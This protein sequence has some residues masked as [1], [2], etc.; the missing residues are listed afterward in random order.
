[1]SV[2]GHGDGDCSARCIEFNVHPELRV[3]VGAYGDL[4]VIQVL[5][6]F[7]VIYVRLGA[8]AYTEIVDDKGEQD[9]VDVMTKEVKG[10]GALDVSVVGKMFDQADRPACGGPYMH[11][12]ISKYTK[13]LRSRPWRR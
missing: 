8:V 13:Q 2:A 5:C 1:V 3:A 10:L 12:R 4:V 11:R 9:V 7:E 6:F